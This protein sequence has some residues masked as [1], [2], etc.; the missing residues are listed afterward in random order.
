[1]GCMV[2]LYWQRKTAFAEGMPFG[3]AGA[4]EF[5]EG[6]AQYF[7]NTADA[8][9]AG[10]VDL[11]LA[12]PDADGLVRFSGDVQMLRPADWS[13]GSRRV[14][15]D[16]GNRGNKRCLQYFNDAVASNTP[17]TRAHAGNGYLMRRGHA[18]VWG[19]WQ[20]DLLP[21][22]GRL[23]LDLPV[24]TQGGAPVR[25]PVRVE[26]I[27]QAGISTFP[28]GVYTSTWRHPAVSLDNAHATLT[29]RRYPW[30][31]RVEIPRSEWCFGRDEGGM[32]LEVFGRDTIVDPSRTHIHLPAGFQPGWIYELVYEGEAPKVL[33]L[34]HAAVRDLVSHL[35]WDAET[36]LPGVE[37]VYGWGRSQTGRAIRDYLYHGFNESLDG[38][39]VFDGLMP[40]VAGAGRLFAGRFGNLTVPAGQQYEDHF[41][42]ADRFPFSFAET[43][44]HLTGRTDAILKRPATDPLVMHSQ[45]ATE[46][47]QRRGSLVHTD[48]RGNDLPQPE[49]VR[50]YHWCGS[51]HAASPLMGAPKHGQ[52]QQLENVIWTS[53]LFRALLDAMDAWATNGTLPPE[54]RMPR[55]SNG[56]ALTFAEWRKQFPQIPGVALPQSP[57]EFALLDFGP[58]FDRTGIITQ[59][60]PVVAD[61]AGYAVLLPAVDADG[62]ELGG[63]R[64]PMVAAP[65]ATYTGWN[66]RARGFAPGALHEYTGATIPFPETEEERAATGDPRPSIQARYGNQAGYVKAIMAA[67][68][69][70]VAERLMLAEDL[71]RVE[72]AAANWHAPR[73]AVALD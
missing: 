68:E 36:P 50:V 72:A 4:Y 6:Q 19:A 65:L 57:S 66:L 17:L 26:F 23:V 47:W 70:L 29:K 2:R 53:M 48:T 54:S 58:E 8:H 62:N 24:A 11:G 44:D 7:V 22:N 42:P 43:T 37:K 16:W 59:E 35:R 9:N 52:C 38:R 71:P 30:D 34:G 14:F 13:R 55:R 60:P 56:T 25:G 20:G 64:A 10:I 40:H 12:P 49:N 18:V 39:R 41:N 21:G 45:T 3:D 5:W 31:A 33:G 28:L 69:Q 27:G 32:G 61:R 15:F 67:A 51:Q 46:Y 73:H 63:V 1:M